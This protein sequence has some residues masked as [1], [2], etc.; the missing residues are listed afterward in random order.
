MSGKAAPTFRTSEGQFDGAIH[1]AVSSPLMNL[2]T[3]PVLAQGE[4]V[5]PCDGTIVKVLRNLTVVPGTAN[6]TLTI[7][8]NGDTDFF[9]D[10]H[11]L[12]TTGNGGVA[13]VEDITSELANTA[14]AAGDIIQFATGGEATSTGNVA[15]VVVIMPRQG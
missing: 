13:G 14:V 11:V 15:A 9:I 12:L 7:G 5:A 2:H 4:F 1:Y 3:A 10:D 8:K 6:A